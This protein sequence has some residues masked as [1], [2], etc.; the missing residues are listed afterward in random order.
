MSVPFGNRKTKFPVFSS[1]VAAPVVMLFIVVQRV[2]SLESDKTRSDRLVTA[3]IA[4]EGMAIGLSRLA[5]HTTLHS[6][7]LWYHMPTYNVTVEFV[8][9]KKP[10]AKAPPSETSLLPGGSGF[11]SVTRSRG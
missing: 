2:R 6:G 11:A 10:R 8:G 1:T 5:T 7:M 4:E 3:S 9:E